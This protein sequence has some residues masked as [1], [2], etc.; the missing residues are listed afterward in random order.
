MSGLRDLFPQRPVA[1][2]AY[3]WDCDPLVVVHAEDGV[4]FA[5]KVEAEY[6]PDDETGRTG[7]VKALRATETGWTPQ[8]R[9]K[10]RFATQQVLDF[11]MQ[12]R[13]GLILIG[14]DETGEAFTWY[15]NG[16]ADRYLVKPPEIPAIEEVDTD[17]VA[18][19]LRTPIDRATWEVKTLRLLHIVREDGLCPFSGPA[20]IKVS[21]SSALPVIEHYTSLARSDLGGWPELYVLSKD[22]GNASGIDAHGFETTWY[23]DSAADQYLHSIPA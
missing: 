7:W 2:Q 10:Q 15:I 11:R 20:Q 12:K 14:E 1:G 19:I 22:P 16:E 4:A 23:F 21:P 8:L 9:F 3:I 6:V 17:A 13:P 5:G 18:Q